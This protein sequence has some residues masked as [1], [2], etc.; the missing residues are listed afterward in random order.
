MYLEDNQSVRSNGSKGTTATI[1]SA[2]LSIIVK[3]LKEIQQRFDHVEKT[4]EEQEFRRLNPPTYVE[5]VNSVLIPTMKSVGVM[6]FPFTGFFGLHQFIYTDDAS[7]AI[8]YCV[9]PGVFWLMDLL[10]FYFN[11]QHTYWKFVRLIYTL[12]FYFFGIVCYSALLSLKKDLPTP[13]ITTFVFL[14]I[15]NAIGHRTL[16]FVSL[17][18]RMFPRN[19]YFSIVCFGFIYFMEMTEK[20]EKLNDIGLKKKKVLYGLAV[21]FSIGY[22]KN[23][24]LDKEIHLAT[25]RY[26]LEVMNLFSLGVQT[27]S[28]EI[29]HNLVEIKNDLTGDLVKP[30]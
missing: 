12:V 29:K 30:I 5:Q 9:F 3:E 23:V 15:T 20:R 26:V 1:S 18:F 8:M 10:T 14:Y 13:E 6:L 25:Q 21:F 11:K 2:Q 27:A 24:F 16:L 28:E 22:Y 4:L 19:E 7:L 17:L